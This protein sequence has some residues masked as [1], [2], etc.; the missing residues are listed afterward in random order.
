[1]VSKQFFEK[2]GPIPLTEIVKEI[3]CTVS[4]SNIKGGKSSIEISS[5]DSLFWNAGNFSADPL[6]TNPG[7]NNFI[8]KWNSPVVDVGHPDLDGDGFDWLT[9]V[10]DQDPDGTR[11]DIGAY[12]FEQIP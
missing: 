8:P 4:F 3:N 9:D 12:Y 2:Q 10:D 7:E 5:S 11:M 6:F 1:M